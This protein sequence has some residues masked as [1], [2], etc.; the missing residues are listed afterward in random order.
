VEDRTDELASAPWAALGDQA[1]T[2]LQDL[3]RPLSRAIVE[4]G[5]FPMR[6]SAFDD[7]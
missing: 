4:A 6:P 7:E 3:V 1:C 2:R 5:T